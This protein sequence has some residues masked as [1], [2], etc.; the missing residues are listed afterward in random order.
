MTRS[1]VAVLIIAGLAALWVLGL[2]LGL[3]WMYGQKVGA[4]VG[5][6]RAVVEH[7]LG[8]PTQDW[9]SADFACARCLSIW[10]RT[11]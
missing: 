7:E 10:R 8:A 5:Q 4:L 3:S 6:T 1:R 11:L 9:V 2:T